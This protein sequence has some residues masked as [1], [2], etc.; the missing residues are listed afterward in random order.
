MHTVGNLVVHRHVAPTLCFSHPIRNKGLF[1]LFPIPVV[2]LRPLLPPCQLQPEL[3]IVGRSF[4]LLTITCLCF[5]AAPLLHTNMFR[6][7][8]S[9]RGIHCRNQLR[10][11]YE[12][13]LLGACHSCPCAAH[14]P[15]PVLWVMHHRK[16][17]SSIMQWT[18]HSLPAALEQTPPIRS[19]DRR[20]MDFGRPTDGTCLVWHHTQPC[21]QTLQVSC[22]PRPTGCASGRQ[23]QPCAGGTQGQSS[24]WVPAGPV[25]TVGAGLA[26]VGGGVKGIQS[27]VGDEHS[28]RRVSSVGDEHSSRRVS[29]QCTT[30]LATSSLTYFGSLVCGFAKVSAGTRP[31]RRPLVTVLRG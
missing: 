4:S 2:P 25:F 5:L 17:P 3:T 22:S 10:R 26:A 7:R 1:E 28:S 29:S 30:L 9:Q 31:R 19:S 14:Q 6:D 21:K 20:A 13:L 15:K 12:N 24:L 27:N 18:R 16:P 11:P 23:L 8:S